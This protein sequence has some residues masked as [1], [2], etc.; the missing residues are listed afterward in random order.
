MIPGLGRSEDFHAFSL[1][2]S[3]FSWSFIWLWLSS[4]KKSTNLKPEIRRFGVAN[5]MAGSPIVS[6]QYYPHTFTGDLPTPNQFCVAWEIR[7]VNNNNSSILHHSNICEH[8]SPPIS[9]PPIWL[10][11]F[12]AMWFPISPHLP[13]GN[14]PWLARKY[15]FKMEVSSWEN[16]R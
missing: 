14:Q 1:L 8:Q 10:P 11:H 2:K 13:S 12:N 16:P 3:P 5:H 15:P 6:P 9:I 4:F 7:D